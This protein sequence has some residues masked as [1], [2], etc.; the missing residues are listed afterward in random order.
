MPT[1]CS[2]G[3]ERV[4]HLLVGALPDAF[5]DFET[6]RQR[7]RVP[8]ELARTVL[9]DDEIAAKVGAEVIGIQTLAAEQL[10]VAGATVEAVVVGVAF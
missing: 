4:A 10:V 5:E 7:V 3:N 2:I 6:L 9:V 8:T 1:R